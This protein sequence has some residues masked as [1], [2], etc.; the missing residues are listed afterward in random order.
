MSIHI[1]SSL[2]QPI[3]DTA[4]KRLSELLP[5]CKR[6]QSE[7]DEIQQLIASLEG[8]ANGTS[9]VTGNGVLAIDEYDASWSWRKKTMHILSKSAKA[10][11]TSEI[12]KIMMD[13][14]PDLDRSKAVSGV[15][16]A[17]TQK[18]EKGKYKRTEIGNVKY[19]EMV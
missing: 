11:S 1:P 8:R 18:G 13:K 10:L 19:Y 6:L 5:E 3:L 7:I 16:V 2:K 15:S 14:E 4:K 17:L 9:S 12:V